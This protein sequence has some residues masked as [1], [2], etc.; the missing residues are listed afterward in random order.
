VDGRAELRR[1][2]DGI[3]LRTVDGVTP[4]FSPD[5]HTIATMLSKAG[6]PSIALWRIADGRQLMKVAGADPVFSHDG[7]L[8]AT[9]QRTAGGPDTIGLWN[10]ADGAPIWSMPGDRIAFSPDGQLLA[11][12]TQDSIQLLR[13]AD[14]QPAGTLATGAAQPVYALAFSPDSAQLRVLVGGELQSWSLAD[15]RIARTIPDAHPES[16]V[17]GGLLGPGGELAMSSY[18][19]GDGGFIR[20]AR[21]TDGATIYKGDWSGSLSFSADG[22]TAAALHLDMAGGGRVSVLDVAGGR[23]ASLALPAYTNISFSPDAQTLA[24]STGYT[25]EL[26]SAIDSALQRT[27][28]VSEPSIGEP[29]SALRYSPDGGAL[30]L[31]G[32]WQVWY[33]D[34][35]FAAKGWDLRAGDTAAWERSFVPG[36]EPIAWAVEPSGVTA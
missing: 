4:M 32:R 25:V 30:A 26:R 34:S 3:V 6:S 12:A 21:A 2:A 24:A 22:A 33:G 20:L 23:A 9:V 7:R 8:V 29:F 31:T 11:S 27:L 36:F 18:S 17:V 28:Q 13:L 14:N 35:G 15:K 5:G 16:A 19:L 1:V 10:T